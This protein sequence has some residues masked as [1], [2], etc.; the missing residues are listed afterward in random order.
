MNFAD[1][2]NGAIQRKGTPICVGLDPHWGQIPSFLKKETSS[3]GEAI[4]LF[5]KGIID[6]ISE[7]VPIVKPQLAFYEKF[8]IDGIKAFSETIKYA[9]EK[10]LLVLADGKR[11]DIGST[12]TAYAEAYLSNA[13][14]DFGRNIDA[15]TV[16]GYLGSDGIRPF[17][18]VCKNE[19]KGIFVLL[20]TS[21]SSAGEL[22]DIE[23]KEGGKM[24]DQIASLISVWGTDLVDESGY[25]SVGAVVGATYPEEAALLRKKLPNTIFLVPGYGAQGGGADDVKPCFNKDGLGAIVNSSRGIIFAYQKDEKYAEKDFA[26]A[27]REATLKMKEELQ[28]A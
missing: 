8:G 3:P 27:A 21:N 28:G 6:A 17:L 12:A 5:N 16:N 11:N 24:L 23:L 7:F 22:Q 13:C 10:G 18:E 15:L 1:T 25:S 20:R 4:F 14:E 19:G 9:K 26:A 2:L